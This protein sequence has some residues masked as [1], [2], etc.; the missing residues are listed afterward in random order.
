MAN[1]TFTGVPN[2]FW[3]RGL[4]KLPMKFNRWYISAIVV[5]VVLLVALLSRMVA[6]VASPIP[7]GLTSRTMQIQRGMRRAYES[8]VA[9]VNVNA[10]MAFRYLVYAKAYLSVLCKL[11]TESQIKKLYQI[12]IH[13]TQDKFDVLEVEINKKIAK[14]APDLPLPDTV[15][16][17]AAWLA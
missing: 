3:T 9:K 8:A 11:L 16:S 5:G 15:T 1:F 17:A 4:H 12:D 2:I 7:A 10:I 6:G 14:A 13:D